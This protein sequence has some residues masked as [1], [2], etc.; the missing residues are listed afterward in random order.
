[1][2]SMLSRAPRLGGTNAVVLFV[3][4]LIAFVV[5]TQVTQ[6]SIFK[7]FVRRH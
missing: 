3:A 5:E 7:S 1:M 4:V 6:V 2:A